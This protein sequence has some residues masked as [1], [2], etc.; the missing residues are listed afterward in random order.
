MS[1]IFTVIA[2]VIALGAPVAAGPFGPV[3]ATPAIALHE[4]ET[5]RDRPIFWRGGE[6]AGVLPA[7]GKTVAVADLP[8]LFSAALKAAEDENFDRH[9]GVDPAGLARAGARWLSGRRAVGGS[10]LTQQ[11]VKNAVTGSK[12]TVWR[13]VAEMISAVETEAVLSKSQILESYANAVF[14]GRRSEGA[15]H[16]ASNWFGRKWKD[17]DIAEIAFLAGVVQA[18]SALDPLRNPDAGPGRAKARRD[19]VLA[20]MQEEGL[21]TPEQREAAS[22]GPVR[23]AAPATRE[24]LAEARPDWVFW[25]RAFA[26]RMASGDA[27]PGSN[28]SDGKI[29]LPLDRDAQEAAWKFLDEQLGKLR[30]TLLDQ[31]VANLA[32][33]GDAQVEDAVS[34]RVSA[35][36]RDAVAL[37]TEAARNAVRAVP[38]GAL[39][40]V[41]LRSG[42]AMSGGPAMVGGPDE[43]LLLCEDGTWREPRELDAVSRS[44]IGRAR[45]GDVFVLEGARLAGRPVV[46]GA[47][48]VVDVATG[49]PVVSV[50]GV[51]SWASQFDRTRARRQ[52]GS[53]IKPFL[54]LAALE[55]GYSP[56]TPVSDAPVSVITEA[57]VWRPSNY[58]GKTNGSVPLYRALELSLNNVAA[59]LFLKLERGAL[60]DAAVRAGAYDREDGRTMRRLALPSAALGSVETTPLRMAGA[61]AALDPARATVASRQDLQAIEA[62]MKG[63]LAR[64]TA[65]RAFRDGPGGIVGKTGTSQDDRDAWFIGR[66]GDMAMAVWIGRDDDGPM[67]AI[68]GRASTGG[69]LA[70]PVAARLFDYLFEKRMAGA[71]IETKPFGSDAGA[72][73]PAELFSD[74]EAR[75]DDLQQ[76]VMGVFPPPPPP[77]GRSREF[78]QADIPLPGADDAWGIRGARPADIPLSGSGRISSAGRAPVN[79]IV[80][81]GDGFRREF[82]R[83]RAGAGEPGS[84]VRRGL[85]KI[86]IPSRGWM[87]RDP[88][89]YE[90][91]IMPGGGLY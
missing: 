77:P 45:Q 89:P 64:G 39:R 63:V 28:P 55:R 9:M 69:A 67:P 57:G 61:V 72:P 44:M 6:P 76:G 3:E 70:A 91:D 65:W 10:T 35:E 34:G 66:S 21:I 81:D 32:D 48:V 53:A 19:Y 75:D 52:P 56:V 17:L 60:R 43:K 30:R 84:I 54:W 15:K 36:D 13:K 86:F 18:P 49:L 50:G 88:V 58:G 2:S 26:R 68:A 37:L 46:Q 90:E 11:L 7:S 51:E 22:D 1:D 78:R 79:G 25:A 23:T 41:V 71:R 20:R 33:Q 87:D 8:P 59:R 38:A 14:F 27:F 29:A 24:E 42:K 5:S 4:P 16:A 82:N 80:S 85:P 31:P 74:I 40:A 73:S 83:S 47:V 62:M 12:R